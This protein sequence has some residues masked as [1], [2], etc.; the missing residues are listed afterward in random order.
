MQDPD[1][2]Q[3]FKLMRREIEA[4]V[5]SIKQAKIDF[6]AAIDRLTVELNALKM[7]VEQYHPGMSKS[8]PKFREEARARNRKTR[9]T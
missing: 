6:T 9:A 3:R 8:Y 2:E 5:S 1:I 7:A 4:T